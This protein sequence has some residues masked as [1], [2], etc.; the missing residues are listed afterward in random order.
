MSVICARALVKRFGQR[1]AVDHL[2][3]DVAPGEIVALVGENGAGKTTALGMLSGQLVPDEGS[4]LLSGYDVFQ[5]AL[6]ARRCLGY[7]S[8]DL[9]LPPHLTLGEMA[10]F[11]CQVKSEPLRQ[12][13]LERLLQLTDLHDDA[14]RLL[15][16]LSYG[17]QRKS[18]W[19]VALV[20]QPRALLLD[21]GLAGLDATSRDALIEE[22][23]RRLRDGLGVLWAEHDLTP[24]TPHVSRVLVLHRG[25]IAEMI[26]GSALRTLA[27]S[28]EL[29]SKMR[30]W[31]S[32]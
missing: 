5:Q 6:P 16:E 12:G 7:V 2:S 4:A 3:L 9:L 21:E 28:G 15:G 29:A 31:T 13:E 32:Y 23:A 27:E 10:E 20:G 22:V 17:M 18:A 14:D 26:S 1:S 30:Q 25:R 8:Q 19:V 24:I 11:A